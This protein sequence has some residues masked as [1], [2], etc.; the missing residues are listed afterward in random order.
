MTYRQSATYQS[1]RPKNVPAALKC[2]YVPTEKHPG[3]HRC[4]RCG[5]WTANLPLY[6]DGV[7]DQKER[8]K[9]ARDRRDA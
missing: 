6:K 5:C 4:T 8:R 1:A 9:G 2:N 3:T 7:C